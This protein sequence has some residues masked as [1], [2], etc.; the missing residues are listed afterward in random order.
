MAVLVLMLLLGFVFPALPAESDEVRTSR[1][2]FSEAAEQGQTVYLRAGCA[3][4]HTQAIRAVVAD[5]GV[6]PVTLSDTNQVIG[7][8]RL[9]PDLADVGSRLSSSEIS[10]VLTGG[11]HPALPLSGEAMDALVAYLTESVQGG[12]S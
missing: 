3:S 7:Y 5:V 1:I 8:R 2:A 4:C 12:G 10:S 11:S 9:G 6:G